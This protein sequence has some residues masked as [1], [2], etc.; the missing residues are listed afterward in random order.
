MKIWSQRSTHYD[1]AS[2]VLH[3]ERLVCQTLPHQPSEGGKDRLDRAFPKE[4]LKL[5]HEQQLHICR[6]KA[7]SFR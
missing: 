7:R 1:D 4:A 5:L 3:L 2:A 6:T